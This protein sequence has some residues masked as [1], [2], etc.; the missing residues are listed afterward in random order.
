MNDIETV[1]S[2]EPTVAQPAQDSLSL[3]QPTNGKATSAT[4]LIG[5][6]WVNSQKNGNTYLGMS[7][8]VA[9]LAWVLD[10]AQRHGKRY[11]RASAFTN[12]KPAT[13]NNPASHRVV[14]FKN[15]IDGTDSNNNAGG[16][17]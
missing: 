11:V 10:Q 2:Q 13:G 17:S 8:N 4:Y 14:V 12:T 16:E 5:S 9:E 6:G 1:Q 7:F 15:D 3:T